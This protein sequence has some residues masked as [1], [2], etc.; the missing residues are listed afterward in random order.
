MKPKCVGKRREANMFYD[1]NF[2]IQHTNLTNP[3]YV[4][5]LTLDSKLD[6]LTV[7]FKTITA[8]SPT[9]A[10]KEFWKPDSEEIHQTASFSLDIEE[11]RMMIKKLQQFVD[12]YDEF[13]KYNFIVGEHEDLLAQQEQKEQINVP[14]DNSQKCFFK[15]TKNKTIKKNS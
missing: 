15:P 4:D 6:S 13:S 11:V 9:S 7:L 2:Y 5:I 14:L 12:I 8:F 10:K 3:N 1:N